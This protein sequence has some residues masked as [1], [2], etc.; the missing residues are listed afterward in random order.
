MLQS[1]PTHNLVA[2]TF[3]RR[4]QIENFV[5]QGKN[6]ENEAR[7]DV[8]KPLMPEAHPNNRSYVSSADLP[9]NSLHKNLAWWAVTRRTTNC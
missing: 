2:A 3:N 5:M 4:L 8:C 1:G 7:T 9:S 6:A